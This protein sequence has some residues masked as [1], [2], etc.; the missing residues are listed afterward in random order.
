MPLVGFDPDL[1]KML[2]KKTQEIGI[3]V[4]LLSSVKKI[5][6]RDNGRKF[7]VYISTSESN[8]NNTEE[9]DIVETDLV[10][11]GAGRIPDTENLTWNRV[12]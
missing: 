3:N 5:D 4:R 6:Y 9:S 2:L 10:V 1:V 12:K 11:H 8:T 7:A